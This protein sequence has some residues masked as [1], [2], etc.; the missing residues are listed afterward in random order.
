MCG[1]GKI[2]IGG[3]CLCV[4]QLTLAVM[5]PNYTTWSEELK[6]N[7]LA[8]ILSGFHSDD[9]PGVGTFYDF[10]DRLWMSDKDNLS[11]H[12][13]PLKKREVEKPKNPDDKAAPIEKISVEELINQLK[14][15]PLST[16]TPPSIN[17]LS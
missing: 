10:C 3:V 14:A 5:P 7:H 6:T 12:A 16:D 17:L 11:D 4:N 1:A 8:A 15:T 9:T 13:Q 2:L